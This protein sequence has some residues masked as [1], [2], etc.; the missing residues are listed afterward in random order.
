MNEIAVSTRTIEKN[1]KKLQE[2]KRLKR[3]GSKKDGIW[4]VLNE[5]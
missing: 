3:S 1:L 5:E 2:V 4:Q